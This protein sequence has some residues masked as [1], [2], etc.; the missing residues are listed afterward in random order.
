MADS[1]YSGNPEGAFESAGPAY[2]GMAGKFQKSHEKEWKKLGRQSFYDD[3]YSS[4]AQQMQG[5]MRSVRE[6]YTQGMGFNT[7]TPMQNAALSAMWAQ[8]P[9][10][11]LRKKADQ[12]KR[13]M[14][15]QQEQAWRATRQPALNFWLQK[16]G[17]GGQAESIAQSVAMQE[18]MMGATP[19]ASGGGGL[20]DSLLPILTGVAAIGGL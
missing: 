18:A 2:G 19:G 11:M 4:H 17:L 13:D 3:F 8:S 16:Q 9:Y 1:I 12:Y 7:Q 14:R 20:L 15:F 5:A 10:P 6:G